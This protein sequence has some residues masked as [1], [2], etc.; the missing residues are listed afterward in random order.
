M[1]LENAHV[2]TDGGEARRGEALRRRGEREMVAPPARPPDQPGA[3]PFE[4]EC[5]PS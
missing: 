1:P 2:T 3:Q 4:F 5:R